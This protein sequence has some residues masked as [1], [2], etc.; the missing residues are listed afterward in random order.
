MNFEKSAK[1]TSKVEAKFVNM[2]STTWDPWMNWIFYIGVRL[3]Y[4][5]DKYNLLFLN[6][7]TK[8]VGGAGVL[9]KDVRDFAG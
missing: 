5:H 6:V 9:K 1:G 4:V 8:F 3:S 2:Y 7:L